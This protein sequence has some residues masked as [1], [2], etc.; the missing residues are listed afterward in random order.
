MT[1]ANEERDF[2][3]KDPSE[4]HKR[5][6]Y[7]SLAGLFTGNKKNC[8]FEENESLNFLTYCTVPGGTNWSGSPDQKSNA[9]RYCTFWYTKVLACIIR[10]VRRKILKRHSTNLVY[11]P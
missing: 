9:F 2:R 3:A 6:H 8:E 1:L 4:N 11:K 5:V 10:I 7:S